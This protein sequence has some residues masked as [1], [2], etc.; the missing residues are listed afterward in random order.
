MMMRETVV[1]P[2]GLITRPNAT[3]QY[4]AGALLTA[5]NVCMRA[6]GIIE[7]L[8]ARSQYA[9]NGG[10]SNAV[11]RLWPRESSVLVHSDAEIVAV[12]DSSR[13]S[14]TIPSGWGLTTNP[15]FMRA[16]QRD[17]VTSG[18]GP[19]SVSGLA[20]TPVG[21]AQPA[22]IDCTAYTTASTDQAL[23]TGR[24]V[25]YR[26]IITRRASTGEL[27]SSAPSNILNVD[28]IAGST[29]ALDIRIRI[30]SAGN[31]QVGDTYEL[32]RTASQASGTDPGN[33][34]RLCGTHTIDAGDIAA[35]SVTITDNCADASLGADLYTNPGQPT[36]SARHNRCPSYATD[37]ATFKGYAFYA[38]PYSHVRG[39]FKLIGKCGVL[40]GSAA[41]RT[42][43][44]GR[45]V[46][47]GDFTNGSPTVLNVSNVVGLKI[48][49][50][51][52][53]TATVPANTTITNIAGTTLTLS[54][55][56]TATNAA[57]SFYTYDRLEIEGV[58]Y[59][60]E[61]LENL[62]EAIAAG[63]TGLVMRTDA[64]L[65]QTLVG[66]A[67]AGGAAADGPTILFEDA[68][69]TS[70]SDSAF[71][72]RATN[73]QNY[74]PAL[75][76]VVGGAVYTYPFTPNHARLTVSKFDQPDHVPDENELVVGSG[77]VHRLIATKDSL[78]AF[79]SDG[80]YAIEG[81][82]GVFR[83]RAVDQTLRLA[84]RS[85]VDVMLDEAWAYTNRGIVVIG[86]EGV[87]RE[88]SAAFVGDLIAGG[89]ITSESAD[90]TIYQLRTLLTC[91]E[92]NREVRL[93]IRSSGTS[94]IYLYN[95]LT[96]KFTTVSDSGAGTEVVA[97]CYV[98]FLESIVWSPSVAGANTPLYRYDTNGLTRTDDA[99]RFQPLF[100]TKEPFTLKQWSDFELVFRNCGSSSFAI[101]MKVNGDDATLA[102]AGTV[103]NGL[104]RYVSGMPLAHGVGPSASFG[105]NSQAN[106]GSGWQLVGLSARWSLLGNQVQ[107]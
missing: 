39:R 86:P 24:N 3:G 80:L 105:F 25:N 34:F 10:G 32:Y 102:V 107:K 1:A 73:G 44:V 52:Q 68:Y 21:V 27:I 11:L 40:G 58:I 62:G 22:S 69:Y 17:F 41:E 8:P 88:I 20:A 104:R 84:T 83:V 81:D 64:Y 4:P 59:D 93:C 42:H 51:L 28:S 106:G 30:L 33:R 65:K 7:P 43:G 60:F 5:T 48:G 96:D 98:P 12:T 75:A 79:T 90:A 103:Q 67:I 72:Y 97:E 85:S 16:K 56:A 92:R 18:G 76:S 70:F 78:F 2:L 15:R 37:M 45:R 55:N 74:S 87:R 9:A 6:P 38:T 29:A 31:Y 50:R 26:A 63:D 66:G 61:T 23:A 77:Y 94:T 57:L 89:A 53:T 49:Q 14:V 13:N 101:D 35:L 36:Q 71:D 95:A 100:G 91:D 47:L 46:Q 54:Q 82:A 19:L 99:I